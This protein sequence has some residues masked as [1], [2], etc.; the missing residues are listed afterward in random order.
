MKVLAVGDIVGKPGQVMIK[1]YLRQVREALEVD[2]CIAN[3]ENAAGNGITRDIAYELFDN[4]VDIITM[5]NHV[6]SKKEIIKLFAEDLRIIRP[7][8]YPP[9]TPGKGHIIV[10][11]HNQKVAIINL[12]GIV[13][14]ENLDCPFRTIEN[15]L[16]TLQKITNIIIIDFHAEATSEKMAMGWY[17]DGRVSAVFGTHTHVQTADERILPKGTG[18]ITD[19]GMTGPY[20]S[21]L[22]VKK[23]IIIGRFLTHLPRRFEIAEG[24]AQFNGIILDID[25]VSGKTRAINRIII[26]D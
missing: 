19:I 15:K 23:E 13:Y 4:G 18:Y 16:K 21:I 10:N 26:N 14:L 2:L 7:A 3:G 12:S 25:E 20:N 8:N 11:V 22:G 1:N 6:W 9:H 24:P 5:G 17:L